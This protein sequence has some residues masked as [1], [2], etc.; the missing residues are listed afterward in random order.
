MDDV[1]QDCGF[2]RSFRTA[3]DFTLVSKFSNIRQ[4]K[5]VQ[6][7]VL[8]ECK[9]VFSVLPT[10]CGK[11]LI[12][13]LV[14]SVCSYLHDEG[15]DYPKN[16][17]LV[18]ICPL[19]SLIDSHIEEL[20]EHGISSCCLGDDGFLEEDV[21]KYSILLTSPELIVRKERWQKLLQSKELQDYLFG[22][23]T[24]EAH[25]VPCLCFCLL[26]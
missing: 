11:S 24:D 1:D 17:I 7:E 23:L 18:M 26:K 2:L 3:V 5:P 20:A 6:E 25:V 12:F 8:L 19:R 22:L 21:L 16:A 4:L 9:D 10:G 13:Q 14:P 15:F